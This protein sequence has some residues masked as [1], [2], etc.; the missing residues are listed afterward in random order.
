MLIKSKKHAQALIL[1]GI[2]IFMGYKGW[3]L[4]GISSFGIS[5]L[6][7]YYEYQTYLTY[8]RIAASFMALGVIYKCVSGFKNIF[9]V[10]NKKVLALNFLFLIFFFLLRYLTTEIG[11]FPIQAVSY[12]VFFNFFT[13]TFEE[14]VFTG[15]IFFP[16]TFFISP[17]RAALITSVTFSLWHIDVT[18][19]Y[20]NL[21]W[22]A[23]FSMYIRYSFQR[24]SS[25]MALALF[26]FLWDQ[27]FFG[28]VWG[29][30]ASYY[31]TSINILTIAMTCFL[32]LKFKK[33]KHLG[34]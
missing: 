34:N 3:K 23:L 8:Y 10:G 9:T 14:F 1:A 29:V 7:N 20:S 28:F 22:I 26:H 5:S 13:G 17:F 24:G 11:L 33:V 32:I 6:S 16:L 25:L 12:E 31:L 19:S 27:I 4:L 21:I 2:L 18:N 15:M 30:M